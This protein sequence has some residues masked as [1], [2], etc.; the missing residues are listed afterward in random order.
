[1]ALFQFRGVEPRVWR[2]AFL[3]C[4][5]YRARQSFRHIALAMK[6]AQSGSTTLYTFPLVATR[7]GALFN[8]HA[9]PTKIDPAAVALAIA[10][11]TKPGETV[12]DGF[13]G[14]GTTALGALLCSRPTAELRQ[15]ARDL[16]LKPR[17]GSRRTVVYEVSGLGSFIAETLCARVNPTAFRREAEQILAACEERYGWL[18]R[19]QDDAGR[20]GE[21]RHTIWSEVLQCQGC[22]HTIAVWDGCVSRSPAKIATEFRC[23]KCRRLQAVDKA[24]RK[25]EETFDD[26][27]GRTVIGRQRVVGQVYG[28]TGRRTWVRNPLP[29]DDQLLERIRD[30]PLP[31]R[32]PVVLMRWGDL[33]RTGYHNGITHLHHFYTR[34]NLIAVAAVREQIENAP[35]DLRNALAFWLSSY[36]AS[37]STIMTR[38][39]AKDGGR[40]LVVTS[41]QS[42]VLYVSGLPVEKNVF[43]GL[44]RKLSTIARAFIEVDGLE[45][46]VRIVRGSSHATDLPTG[47]VDYVF[48][49]PPFGGNIPYSE[50]NF[51]SEAWLG[52]ITEQQPEAIV[53]PAQ[54]KGIVEYEQLL[55][56]CFSEFRRVLKPG[57]AATVTFHSSETAVW[58]ALMRSFERSGFFVEAASILDKRQGSF[59]QITTANA[60][61]GDALLLLRPTRTAYIQM[62]PDRPYIE[63]MRELVTQAI[64]QGRPE[65]RSAHRLYSRFISRYVQQQAPPPIDAE[66]FYAALTTHFVR[67]GQLGIPV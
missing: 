65:E 24:S 3:T 63:V 54:E 19:A 20:T 53:S 1:M 66:Q 29:K 15:R 37:H 32:V 5:S 36:N 10:C 57:G 59:K 16:G 41:N 46:D 67:R 9:Y 43:R 27:L 13:G 6:K 28:V 4:F 22:S 14:S 38:V 34:R 64:A 17:W 18:Y 52:R 25:L 58:T 47:T 12:F 44:R 40:E 51:I 30:T 23:P 42:G 61:K 62:P 26:I 21:I 33:R 7:G 56:R 45:G 50:A 55:Q 11:H 60:V 31:G 49:D 35:P 48:S 2:L 39:V 8:A